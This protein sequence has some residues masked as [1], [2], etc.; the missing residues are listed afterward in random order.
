MFYFTF[1]TYVTYVLMIFCTLKNDLLSTFSG[2][3]NTPSVEGWRGND[4][5][6]GFSL[7]E[8]RIVQHVLKNHN[9]NVIDSSFSS[10]PRIKF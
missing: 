2:P 3:G 7:V 4:R 9:L 5:N 10:V 6:L 1:D 8:A